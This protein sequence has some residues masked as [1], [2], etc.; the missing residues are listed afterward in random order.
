MRQNICK[1]T[2]RLFSRTN[3]T[4]I[5]SFKEFI[6]REREAG[7]K[8]EDLQEVKPDLFQ[9]RFTLKTYGCAMNENDS[10]IVQTILNKQNMIY[11]ADVNKSELILLNTCAIREGAESKVWNYI[12]EMAFLKRQKQKRGEP[13][14]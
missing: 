14:R 11:E 7:I 3:V 4:G 2:N 1:I 5:P 12:N 8:T 6:G 10:E 13:S 9:K